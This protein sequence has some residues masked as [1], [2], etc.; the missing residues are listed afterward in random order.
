VLLGLGAKPQRIN[1]IDDLAQVV[2]ALD[3]VL[4]LGK[5]LPDLV[6]DGIRTGGALREP[7]QVGEE[8]LVDEVAKIIPGERLVMIQRSVLGFGRRPGEPAIGLLKDVAVF[9]ALER[10]FLNLVLL[11]P[12][13]VFQEQQPGGLLCVVELGRASGFF[14]QHVI[15]IAECL[16]KH[17]NPRYYSPF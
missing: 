10:S 8:L 14:A 6:L 12:I 17:V 7:L 9:L 4:E 3:L 13:E 2:A 11:E 16:F 5:D 1:M 15:D